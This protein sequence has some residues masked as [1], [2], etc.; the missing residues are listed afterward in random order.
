MVDMGCKTPLVREDDWLKI[1]SPQGDLVASFRLK[2]DMCRA[3]LRHMLTFKY[4]LDYNTCTVK[5]KN[6]KTK[7]WKQ[8]SLED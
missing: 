3:T 7:N 6:N 4:D 2:E 5:H 8:I 1:E